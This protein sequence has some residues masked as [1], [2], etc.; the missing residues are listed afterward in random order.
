MVRCQ[1]IYATVPKVSESI[2]S[3]VTIHRY[4]NFMQCLLVFVRFAHT[5]IYIYIAQG[6]L[7]NS[8]NLITYNGQPYSFM[9][10]T[11]SYLLAKD[12]TNNKFSVLANYE[13]NVLKSISMII[14]ND[15]TYM[16]MAGGKVSKEV[17]VISE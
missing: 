2:E 17:F 15:Q 6:V 12:L 10:N 4:A 7:I 11:G 1:R 5:F 8:N 13:D 16:L 9:P 14:D 3:I